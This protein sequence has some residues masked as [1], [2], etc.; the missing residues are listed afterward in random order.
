MKSTLNRI[1]GSVWR[2]RGLSL[3]ELLIALGLSAGL[4]L[5]V[6]T[7][8]INSNQTSRLS[9]SL[10]RIQEAGRVAIDIISHDL[11]MVS[12]QGC[13][14][15]D[16]VE[17][18]IIADNPPTDIFVNT[19]LQG[20][21]VE[22]SNWAEGTRFDDTS[23]ESNAVIGS[24]VILIQ[25]GQKA[26]VEITGNMSSANANI[27]V[28]GQSGLFQQ[29]DIVII[30]DCENVDMFRITNSPSGENTTLAHA[31]GSNSDNRL[32]QAYDQTATIMTFSSSAYFV[33][34]TG[35][36]DA[37]GN[38]IYSLYQQR[39]NM[40]NN[41]TPSF[42]VNELVEGVESM[43]ILY[44]Q[45][46]GGTIRFV[47]AGT[48][49]LN[50]TEVVAIRLGLLISQ[51]DNVRDNAD[52]LTYELPGETIGTSGT[53]THPADRRIRRVFQTTINLRNRG[54]L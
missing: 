11:R 20:W 46:T 4:I 29:D 2:S 19:A 49:G 5:G 7:I 8:Y 36:D 47:P 16:T 51:A 34:D 35:R 41:A 9:T 33:A 31:N 27:Q 53:V 6:M 3:V 45:V 26:P 24:D 43:Q 17:M 38:P 18:T 13:A 30:S 52:T 37:L 14:D 25:R 42:T 15:P 50:M 21:E 48:T 28:S 12:F 22:D 44:G 23:I 54:S 39:D 1:S 32:S 40:Q 10:A